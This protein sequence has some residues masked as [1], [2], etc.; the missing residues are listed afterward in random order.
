[1]DSSLRA[2]DEKETKDEQRLIEN[3]I[4]RR[5]ELRNEKEN[6]DV[7]LRESNNGVPLDEELTCCSAYPYDEETE[8]SG[9]LYH[10]SH[11]K[12]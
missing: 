6:N 11:M 2:H 3:M 4:H 10:R 12:R 8:Y 5:N 1:M 7:N 9:L